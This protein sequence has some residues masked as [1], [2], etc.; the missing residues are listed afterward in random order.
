MHHSIPQ[1]MLK[2]ITSDLLPISLAALLQYTKGTVVL[3]LDEVYNIL[4]H[5]DFDARL[6]KDRLNSLPQCSEINED[7]FSKELRRIEIVISSCLCCRLHQPF[8]FE[9]SLSYKS[10]AKHRS[11]YWAL[12]FRCILLLS[13]ILLHSMSHSLCNSRKLWYFNHL[14][15]QTHLNSIQVSLRTRTYSYINRL[16][17]K[18]IIWV[19]SLSII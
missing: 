19:S 7:I 8:L 6:F 5:R 16:S 18:R 3:C 13:P 12:K 10:I 17:S 1:I 2:R 11:F 15:Y 4:L 9:L 14:L